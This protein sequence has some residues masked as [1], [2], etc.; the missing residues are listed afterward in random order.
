[1][2]GVEQM[3]HLKKLY[4]FYN[5]IKEISDITPIK[6]LQVIAIEKH[7]ILKIVDDLNLLG[8]KYITLGEG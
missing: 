8:I 7:K 3:P 4:M 5:P 1:M 2:I 6:N